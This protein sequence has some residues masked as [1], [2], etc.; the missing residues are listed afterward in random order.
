MVNLPKPGYYSSHPDRF[1]EYEL[2]HVAKDSD[3][4]IA[5]RAKAR[6]LAMNEGYLKSVI[7]KWVLP[8]SH[9]DF[10]D[11]LEE[12]RISFLSAIENYDL[13]Y[14]VSIRS[15]A[16][17]YLLELQKTY[18]RK[19]PYV[20]LEDSHLAGPYTMENTQF[21]IFNLRSILDQAIQNLTTVEQQVIQLH[22]FKGL[23]KRQIAKQRG[24]SEARISQI[25]RKA[26][27]KMKKW[28]QQRGI[29]PSIL[30]LN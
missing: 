6:L 7:N 13:Q 28:L 20:E 5:N 3:I 21:R 25:V 8:D 15:Y 19:S 24:C 30:E 17:Y 27:P 10:Q 11:L 9:I 4:T 16:R 14:D 29:E 23:R 1:N 22:Y 12:A 26:L 18:F 2:L